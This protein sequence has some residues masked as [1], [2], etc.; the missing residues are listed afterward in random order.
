MLTFI[1][2]T[3]AIASFGTGM[4]FI[5][6]SSKTSGDEAKQRTKKEFLLHLG[7]ALF[8]ASIVLLT[9]HFIEHAERSESEN[10]LATSMKQ[11]I[12]NAMLGQGIISE[13]VRKELVDV[14]RETIE[15]RDIYQKLTFYDNGD[16]DLLA[17]SFLEWKVKNVAPNPTIYLGSVSINPSYAPVDF[18]HMVVTDSNKTKLFDIAADQMG[19]YYKLFQIINNPQSTPSDTQRCRDQIDQL[20]FRISSK[21]KIVNMVKSRLYYRIELN[22]WEYVRIMIESKNHFGYSDYQSLI[23]QRPTVGL[24]LECL[25]RSKKRF[26]ISSLANIKSSEKESRFIARVDTAQGYACAKVFCGMYPFQSVT[27]EWKVK[28]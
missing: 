21:V 19:H 26:E 2:I 6:L 3:I 9:I 18:Q 22:P 23:I 27:I 7:H 12:F 28:K 11:D 16:T 4:F 24:E 15:F 14:F 8:I 25:F 5:H 20:T 17:N 10:Q 1:L 13:D